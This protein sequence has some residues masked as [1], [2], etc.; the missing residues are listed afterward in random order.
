LAVTTVR[1][2]IFDISYLNRGHRRWETRTTDT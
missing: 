2:Q 1:K